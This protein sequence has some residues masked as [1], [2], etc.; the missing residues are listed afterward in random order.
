MQRE[1]GMAKIKRGTEKVEIKIFLKWLKRDNW[2]VF[3]IMNKFKSKS[4]KI[5]GLKLKWEKS[6]RNIL[7][8]CMGMMI[9]ICRW[10]SLKGML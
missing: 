2:E 3:C 6:G 1:Q 5:I 9:M 8:I 4:G 7:E 10:L